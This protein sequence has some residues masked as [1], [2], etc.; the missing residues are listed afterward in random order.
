MTSILQNTPYLTGENEKCSSIF[1]YFRYPNHGALTRIPRLSCLKNR[2]W[3]SIHVIR[4][5]PQTDLGGITHNTDHIRYERTGDFQLHTKNMFNP[6]ASFRLRSVALS[7]PG[8]Q[9]FPSVASPVT[10]SRKP[11]SSR[12]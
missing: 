11:C 6:Y 3:Q 12:I 5:I 4:Q 10:L 1:R 9:L 7:L 8:S 2:F